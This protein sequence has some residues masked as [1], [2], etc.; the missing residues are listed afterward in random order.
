MDLHCYQLD[1]SK[2]QTGHVVPLLKIITG[3]PLLIIMAKLP[4]VDPDTEQHGL[5]S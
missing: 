1:I 4:G 5:P 2:A 3:S